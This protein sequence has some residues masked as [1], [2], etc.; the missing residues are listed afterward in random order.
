MCL[1]ELVAEDEVGRVEAAGG[2]GSLIARSHARRSVPRIQRRASVGRRA[3]V[4]SA[5]GAHLRARYVQRHEENADGC[6]GAV[7]ADRVKVVLE[8]MKQL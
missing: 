5:G 3:S 2:R 8:N 7:L 6:R 4:R 1:R